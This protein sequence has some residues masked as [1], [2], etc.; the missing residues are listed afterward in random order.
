MNDSF[1]CVER[2]YKYISYDT[3]SDPEATSFPSTEKQK[4]LARELV[5]ELH[6]L[7]LTDA[8]MD[9]WGYVYAT[10]PSNTDIDVPTIGLIAHLDTSPDVSG[11]NVQPILHKNYQGGDLK[12]GDS[13]I[14]ILESENPDLAHKI[15]HDIITSDG[16]TL[17]GADD[18][19]GIAEIFDAIRYLQQNPAVKHGTIKI[20]V[21][22]DEE[23]GKGADHFDVDRFGADF[24][25]TIDGETVG[26][27]EDE[28]FCADAAVITI[29]GVNVH[30]G[31]AKNKMINSIKLACHIIEQLPKHTL[32]PETT[33]KREGYVHPHSFV[34]NEEKTV[35]KFLIR[36]FTVD[37][38]KAKENF[39]K[40][41][42]DDV[43][44][45][46]PKASFDFEIVEYYRNMK[47]QLE[48]EPRVVDYALEAVR[49]AGVKP[50]KSAIRG[51]TDGARLSYMGLLTPN[52]FA[53]GHNFHSRQEYISIQDMKKAVEVIINIVKIWQEKSRPN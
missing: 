13:G 15:G 5:N 44:A 47:Y 17:L 34:G 43:M 50:A 9:E 45:H 29:H 48:K 40:E 22:P 23:V 36:D 31:Y 21:T 30:P 33:D 49:R 25:Y 12:L 39:L 38:L 7:G 8:M 46:V 41:I 4:V 42:C 14:V 10:L 28:T 20:A 11:K 24:A 6:E 1:T 3:Q 26:E 2:F 53:G 18:K 37:G 16:T 35:V 52:V 51:G 32:S 27:I 19:A